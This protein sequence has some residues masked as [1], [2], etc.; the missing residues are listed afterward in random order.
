MHTICV[1]CSPRSEGY[2]E[3]AR[4]RWQSAKVL[5]VSRTT[6]ACVP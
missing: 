4:G 6:I 2:L 5:G 3:N 1:A